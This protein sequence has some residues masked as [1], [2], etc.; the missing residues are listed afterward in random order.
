MDD[1]DDV[2]NQS[3]V[4]ATTADERPG[5]GRVILTT[6]T[7]DATHPGSAE[8]GA[9]GARVANSSWTLHDRR[10]GVDREPIT[11]WGTTVSERR[12]LIARVGSDGAVSG[13][14]EVVAPPE[15]AGAS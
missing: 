9:V 10:A 1:L 8:R 5:P 14:G 3:V 12:N 4:R 13:T 15:P 7:G 11:A 2:L 6:V